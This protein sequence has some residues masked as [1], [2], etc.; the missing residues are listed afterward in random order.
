MPDDKRILNKLTELFICKNKILTKEIAIVWVTKLTE[1]YN[2]DCILEALEE[3]IWSEDDFPTVGKIAKYIDIIQTKKL[4]IIKEGG[5]LGQKNRLQ[6][7]N[8]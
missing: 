3:M 7:E 2:D 8:A 4:Q 5:I 6:I 1:I